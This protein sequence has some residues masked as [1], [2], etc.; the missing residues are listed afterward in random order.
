MGYSLLSLFVLESSQPHSLFSPLE[1]FF[2][3]NWDSDAFGETKTFWERLH[4]FHFRVICVSRQLFRQK[5]DCHFSNILDRFCAMSHNCWK[6]LVV[7][8]CS[9]LC[10]TLNKKQKKTWEHSLY[11]LEFFIIGVIKHICPGLI[12]TYRAAIQLFFSKTWKGV[13]PRKGLINARMTRLVFCCSRWGSAVVH[14][15]VEVTFQTNA[16]SF[17]FFECGSSF[18][19]TYIPCPIFRTKVFCWLS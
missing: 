4:Y 1:I 17:S 3:R 12:H 19:C 10:L 15:A 11:W 16:T 9:L 2:Y 14:F 6:H 13:C 5:L 8:S 7:F 18:W